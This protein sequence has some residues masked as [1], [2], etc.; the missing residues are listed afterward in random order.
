MS[1]FKSL[2]YSELRQICR[3]LRSDVQECNLRADKHSLEDFLV[4]R[5][6]HHDVT[7]AEEGNMRAHCALQGR[8]K[9]KILQDEHIFP[10]HYNYDRKPGLAMF[11]RVRNTFESIRTRYKSTYFAD[12][13]TN[14]IYRGGVLQFKDPSSKTSEYTFFEDSVYALHDDIYV[15]LQ[16]ILDLPRY[17]KSFVCYRSLGRMLGGSGMTLT[18]F[19]DDYKPGNIL[20]ITNFMSTGLIFNESFDSVVLKIT[21]PA[22]FPALFFYENCGFGGAT[23]NLEQSEVILPYTL[24][25]TGKSLTHG[26]KIMKVENDVPY[27]TIDKE[28]HRVRMLI[29]VEIVPLPRPKQLKTIQEFAEHAPEQTMEE[30]DHFSGGVRDFYLK[31]EEVKKDSQA[32]KTYI[33]RWVPTATARVLRLFKQNGIDTLESFGRLV[34]LDHLHGV[35]PTQLIRRLT[36]PEFKQTLLSYLKLIQFLQEEQRSLWSFLIGR[37]GVDISTARE[38][39]DDGYMDVDDILLMDQSEID[40]WFT[41]QQWDRMHHLTQE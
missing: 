15:F 13:N 41:K 21:V 26:L 39:I 29:T 23:Q 37:I 35:D 34:D 20:P 17:P 27:F 40:Q 31:Y 33:S 3:E 5:I 24:D 2:S 9:S 10:N 11:E 1:V 28:V 32:F 25:R 30:M 7:E 18:Q 36:T 6:D 16:G 4:T 12:M 8:Y 38:I 22:N 14:L 19:Q